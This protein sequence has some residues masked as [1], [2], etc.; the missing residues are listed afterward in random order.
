MLISA[1]HILKS[2]YVSQVLVIKSC[3]T[4][5]LIFTIVIVSTSK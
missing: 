3:V 2:R 4:V 1:P 5:M